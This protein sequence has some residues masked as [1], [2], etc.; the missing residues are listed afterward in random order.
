MADIQ[1]LSSLK[2]LKNLNLLGNPLHA[3]PEEDDTEEYRDKVQAL[4]PSL[5]VLDGKR[6]T[7]KTYNYHN[8]EL[9]AA[10]K[11][12]N[13][14]KLAKI[15]AKK[16]AAEEAKG[17]GSGDVVDKKKKAEK[18]KKKG[19]EIDAKV[20]EVRKDRARKLQGEDE[21]DFSGGE[22]TPKASPVAAPIKAPAVD[23]AEGD[24]DGEK[25]KKRKRK[26]KLG[27][28]A[29]HELEEEA[30]V[31]MGAQGGGAQ[32]TEAEKNK[33]KRAKQAVVE[34]ETTLAEDAVKL[35][36]QGK[37]K[38]PK[39]KRKAAEEGGENA[40][41]A[42]RADTGVLEVQVA[43]EE[44]PAEPGLEAALGLG[45]AIGQGGESAW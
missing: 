4:C 45:A 32:A 24:D 10:L 31:T 13:E 27:Q 34:E 19:A 44:E 37:T 28:D 41:A 6:L 38:K 29:L 12:R 22:G 35:A 25:K 9:R 5:E 8:D 14:A 43:A 33:I 26:R 18:K 7:E 30:A 16:D 42:K 15:K 23:V 2:D 11:K 36:L 39:K 21:A 17:D 40:A 20:K 3:T 1:V